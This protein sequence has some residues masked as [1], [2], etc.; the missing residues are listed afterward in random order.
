MKPQKL[1]MSNGRRVI[2]DYDSRKEEYQSYNKT[3][4]R[5]NKEVMQFYNSAIWRKTS[6]QIL[7]ANDY[8][9]AVCGGEATMT[10]HIVSVKKD[11]SKRLDWDNLQPICKACN[12]AKGSWN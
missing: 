11:W 4:W 2:A 6:K 10:D 9:C 12:D 7:L 1:I 8:I 3:R 5:Y